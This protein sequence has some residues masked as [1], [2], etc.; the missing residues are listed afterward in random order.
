MPVQLPM[1][2]MWLAMSSGGEVIA[3]PE[4]AQARIAEA[5]ADAD[6]V[7]TVTAHGDTVSFAI[8]HVGE[9]FTIDVTT[10]A[11]GAVLAVAIHDAGAEPADAPHAY[12]WLARE[13]GDMQAVRALV[14]GDDGQITLSTGDGREY[15]VI[16]DRHD[17]NSA[18]EARWGAAW[19]NS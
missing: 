5:L 19:E 11:N 10:G 17:G 13:A 18:V 9:R 6:A 1:M 3:D 8:D 15:L 7:D 16:P 4:A 14:V 2:V 12:D